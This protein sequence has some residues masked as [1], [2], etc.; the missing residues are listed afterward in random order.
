[1]FHLDSPLTFAGLITAGA[2]AVAAVDRALFSRHRWKSGSDPARGPVASSVEWTGLGTTAALSD[3]G[4]IAGR[5]RLRADAAT[6]A[7]ARGSLSWCASAVEYVVVPSGGRPVRQIRQRPA[8]IDAE[9]TD[10]SH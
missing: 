9:R 5:G 6:A 4:Q 10:A 1:M 3:E 2:Y 8:H 7:L